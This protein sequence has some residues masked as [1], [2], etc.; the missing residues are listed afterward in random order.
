MKHSI[1]LNISVEDVNTIIEI[2]E[3]LLKE[4]AVK[5]TDLTSCLEYSML[6][7]PK[8]KSEGEKLAKDEAHFL[9]QAKYGSLTSS[10]FNEVCSTFL[11]RKRK[12]SAECKRHSAVMIL[13]KE[14]AINYLEQRID[15]TL[16]LIIYLESKKDNIR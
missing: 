8:L 16:E 6:R 7:H 14:W 1:N 11:E 3:D 5:H 4:Y 13:E 15:Q 9:Q 10:Y 12:H 2:V